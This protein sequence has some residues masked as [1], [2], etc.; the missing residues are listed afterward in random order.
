MANAAVCKTVIRRFDSCLRLQNFGH[1]DFR[2]AGFGKSC[3]PS[4]LDMCYRRGS[5]AVGSSDGSMANDIG[6]KAKLTQWRRFRGVARACKTL[7]VLALANYPLL[8]IG[9]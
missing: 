7:L 3:L 9:R 4:F 2:R 8:H 6:G 5:V 1:G